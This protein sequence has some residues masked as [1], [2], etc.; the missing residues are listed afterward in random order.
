V[1]VPD[2]SPIVSLIVSTRGRQH[3]LVELLD[4]LDRQSFKDFE[5][6]IVEQNAESIVGSLLTRKKRKFPI[7][8]LHTGGERG[9]S[10]GRNRGLTE[11]VGE[12]LV[13]PDDDCWYPPHF[14][15]QGLKMMR[16]QNLDALTGRPTNE[17]GE[18]I[19]GRFESHAQWITTKNVWTTQIEWAALWRRDLLLDLAGYDEVVGVGAPSPW[20]SAEGQ[21]LMIRALKKG[22]RCWYEPSLNA[23]DAGVDR[24]H[25]DS[26]TIA[27]ARAYGRGMGYVLRKQQF[28][29]GVSLYMLS[30][31]IGGA[32]LAAVRGRRRLAKFHG[33]TAVGRLEGIMGR[34]FRNL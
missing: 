21:D 34:C 10:R 15:E 3:Q 23:H 32:L 26:A 25:A 16:E 30:R 5:L 1:D 14:L 19:Q 18:P 13:F 2:S 24:R 9:L 29:L 17:K 7:R 22:A 28:G 8:H 6:I 4:S 31:A 27:K 11:A 33:A 20:Q 12:I